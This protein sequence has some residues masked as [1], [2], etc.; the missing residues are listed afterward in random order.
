MDDCFWRSAPLRALRQAG[1]AY[2][3]AVVSNTM[4][5]NFQAVR[6]GQAVTVSPD[7]MLPQGVR[8]VGEEEDL[9]PLPNERIVILKGQ[10]APQPLT[11]AVAYII[12]ASFSIA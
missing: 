10:N 3:I 5:G 6:D 12:L 8:V 4:Q 2:S 11:D 7:L 1:R 9:P